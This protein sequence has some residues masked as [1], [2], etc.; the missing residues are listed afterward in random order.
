MNL[1]NLMNVLV[2]KMNVYTHQTTL[3]ALRIARCI[4]T[5]ISLCWPLGGCSPRLKLERQFTRAY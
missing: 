5:L 1:T 2:I 3:C 4:N